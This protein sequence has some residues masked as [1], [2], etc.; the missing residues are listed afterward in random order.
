MPGTKLGTAYVQIIPSADGI[1]GS[2]TN[3]FS[4]ESENAG[5]SG[6]LKFVGAMKKVI[7]AAGIGIAVKKALDIGGDLQQSY[8]GGLETLYGNAAQAARNY[9]DEAYK[10][11]ISM[12]SYS[13]QA[14]SFGAALKSAYGG[15]VLKA[16]E[17][18]NTAIMDMADNSA[19]MGTDISSVQAAYQGFAKQNYT[20]LDNLKLGYGGTKSEMERLLKKA[21]EL[22]AEQGKI[23]NYSIDN[24][25]DVYEAIHVVQE[26]LGLTGVAAQ[27]ASETLSGSFGAMKAAAENFAGNL[28]L[29]QNVEESMRG[30]IQTASTFFF[31]NLLP[32]IGTLI[33]SLPG[34]IAT[35]MKEGIPLLLENILSFVSDIA[36][37]VS[38]FADN[39]T[40]EKVTEWAKTTGVEM[41]KKGG[42]LLLNFVTGLLENIDVLLDAL[43]RIGLEIV[44]GLG[45]AIWPKVV[46]AANGIKERFLTV[47]HGLW[48]GVK[49]TAANIRDGFM[50]KVNSIKD[51]VKETA[52]S[53]KERFL[54]PINNLRDKIKEIVDKIKG[55]FSFSISAPH[56]PLPHFSLNPSGWKL[57]DLLQ[58][59]I[60]SLGISWY[61]K[62]MDEPRLFTKATLFGAGETG[63]EVMYGKTNLLRDIKA[64]AGGDQLSDKLARKVDELET[65]MDRIIDLLSAG[66]T[67][68]INGERMA[69]ALALDM[70]AALGTVAVRKARG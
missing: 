46:E 70:D 3:L 24:L 7:A 20:M 11:G 5:K 61:D 14:V 16:A 22:N 10:A 55:F 41:L 1:K 37:G 27:E 64:A 34:A 56:I 58:G 60:P 54:T 53:I 62:A 50:S 40:G 17:A 35:F 31:N 4:G 8:I 23:T 45:A 12:N 65:K 38:T 36:S 25:G 42:E 57:G 2:L 63:D 29:G 19:K 44:T 6:G 59:S 51:Q 9:A 66:H 43:G 18:A 26:D 13:E 69:A 28:A 33:K 15:D 47:L 52:N 32:M 67:L 21:N 68:N 30:L 39:I 48:E 49:E